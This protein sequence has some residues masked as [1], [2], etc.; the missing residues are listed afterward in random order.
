MADNDPKPSIP[1]WQ[2]AG[3]QPTQPSPSS[4]PPPPL[5]STDKPVETLEAATAP[6]EENPLHSE[7]T[8]PTTS[9][10]LTAPPPPSQS[11]T[12]NPSE[13]TAFTTTH[14]PQQAQS[15]SAPQQPTPRQAPAPIITYPEFLSRAH[16]PSPLIT[17]SRLLNA[18]YATAGLAALCYGF[19]TYLLQPMHAQLTHSRQELQVHTRDRMG[20]LNERLEKLVGEDGVREVRK[21]RGVVKA[22]SEVRQKSAE[23]DEDE[24]EDDDVSSAADDPTELFHRDMGTQ[25]TSPLPSPEP[26]ALKSTSKSTDWRGNPIVDGEA[27]PQTPADR[28]ETQLQILHSHLQDLLPKS[29]SSSS[30]TTNLSAANP[31]ATMSPTDPQDQLSRL[32]TLTE[33]LLYSSHP[34]AYSTET[35]SFASA[36]NQA[37]QASWTSYNGNENVWTNTNASGSSSG[38]NASGKKEEQRRDEIENLRKEIRS[39][40]GVLLSAKRFPGASGR[41]I[42]AGV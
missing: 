25:T 40:K 14:H 30:D 11:L 13:F 15:Q 29:A 8:E 12:L 37:N 36:V 31:T 22:S 16:E 21:K 23:E 42:G 38:V 35:G 2:R 34:Y 1:A 4:P 18:T 32:R 39:V 27:K 7:I 10:A 28:Q 3:A 6:V 9:T 41:P 17:T 19:G 26:S 20:E 5:P 33:T 24:D